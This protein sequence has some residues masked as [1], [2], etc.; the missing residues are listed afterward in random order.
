MRS[1]NQDNVSHLIGL[2]SNIETLNQEYFVELRAAVS[3]ARDS[4]LI[5]EEVVSLPGNIYRTIGEVKLSLL[6]IQK[7][8]GSIPAVKGAATPVKIF[9][10]SIGEFGEE[11]RKIDV[12]LGGGTYVNPV[13]REGLTAKAIG[14]LK[15]SAMGRP[16]ERAALTG[17]GVKDLVIATRVVLDSLEGQMS[18]IA[19]A[20]PTLNNNSTASVIDKISDGIQLRIDAMT[21]A[22]T[23][24][25]L[26][27]SGFEGTTSFL[28]ETVSLTNEAARLENENVQQYLDNLVGIKVALDAVSAIFD[29]KQNV[30]EA[31]SGLVEQLEDIRSSVGSVLEPL[32]F[33][34]E[35]YSVLEPFL[36]LV[37]FLLA[38]FQAAFD[39]ALEASG[40]KGLLDDLTG[41]LLSYLGDFNSIAELDVALNDIFDVLFD[42]LNKIDGPITALTEYL[43]DDLLSSL[44][45]PL[46]GSSDIVSSIKFGTKAAD[47]LTGTNGDDA[48]AGGQDN[49]VLDG[50]GGVDRAIF[51]SN[52]ADYNITK[53][54]DGTTWTVSHVRS[55]TGGQAF[56]GT[57]TLHNIEELIFADSIVDLASI[58]GQFILTNS[59]DSLTVTVA[60]D[61]SQTGIWDPSLNHN[62]LYSTP[63][64][65]YV[66]G[67]V[68]FDRVYGG[69]GDDIIF[70]VENTNLDWFYNAGDY[71]DG[72]AGDDFI[73]VSNRDDFAIGGA[74]NDT[75]SFEG[76]TVG[77]TGVRLGYGINSNFFMPSLPDQM[78]IWE[79]EDLI[80]SKFAD[81]F[82]GDRN[83]A[84]MTGG[85]GN[86][87]IRGLGGNDVLYGNSGD[88]VLIGDRGRD[89]LYGGEGRDL[90]VGGLGN[91]LYHGGLDD[92]ML[93]YSAEVDVRDGSVSLFRDRLDEIEFETTGYIENNLDLPDR[94]VVAPVST[95]NI[96]LQ[97]QVVVK[98]YDENGNLTGQDNLNDI[99]FIHGTSGDDT[100][101]GSDYIAQTMIGG[102]GNDKFFAGKVVSAFGDWGLFGDI[103]YG[104][105]GD[106][107]F[108][109][110]AAR[111][112][113]YAGTGNDTVFISG[114]DHLGGDRYSGKIRDGG[115]NT[116]DLS[117]S[118]YAWRIAFDAATSYMF[119]GGKVNADPSLEDDTRISAET[120][121]S[122]F[123]LL[124]HP[125]QTSSL[126]GGW[127][128]TTSFNVFIGSEF[129]DIIN[130]G[131]HFD[132][133]SRYNY[134]EAFGGAGDDII[135]GAQT[136]GA[137]YGGEG[138]DLLGTYNGYEVV[139]N[140][141][142]KNKKSLFDTDLRTILDGGNGND[143]FIAGDFQETFIGGEGIDS[144]SYHATTDLGRDN[145]LTEVSQEGVVV[146]LIAGTGSSGFAKGDLISGIENVTGSENSDDI[147]GDGNANWLKG[148][149]GDDVIYGASG[150]DVLD[151]DAG[152][153]TLLGGSGNDKLTGGGSTDRLVGGGGDDSL[154]GGTGDD[155]I[156]GGTGKDTLGGGNGVDRLVGG[157]DDDIYILNNAEDVI[158]EEKNGGYDTV[159]VSFDY[160]L[161]KYLETIFLDL[162][163]TANINGIGNGLSNVIVGNAGNNKLLGKGGTDKLQGGAG[164]DTL[165]G[166]ND[167]DTITG[168]DA[169][170]VLKGGKGNDVLK[171][172][173]GNDVLK[174][175]NSKDVLKGGE[176][177]DWLSGGKKSDELGG[178]DGND[179]LTGDGDS[180]KFIFSNGNDKITDFDANDDAETIDLSNAGSIKGFK[181]LKNNH[182]S[183][184]GD[185]VVIVDSRGNELIIQDVRLSDLGKSDFL[186]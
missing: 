86:D 91:D 99:P 121:V 162:D 6:P 104:G 49:D 77:A 171:G 15:D 57:D 94:I 41:T 46:V 48:L 153:D 147:T 148:L 135:F 173:K 158:F 9:R 11:A 37:S 51:T 19:V 122:N 114:S 182:M 139:R 34:A 160:T 32:D 144:L 3:I 128:R 149:A 125:R 132:H 75:V 29:L 184:S 21:S 84:V 2:K 10:E 4:V 55:S 108:V 33:V 56:D 186:F 116:I 35:A 145:Y 61:P 102:D 76:F 85:A 53:E 112:V 118:D 138:D 123:D 177:D 73:T 113:F 105:A 5:L 140:S 23:V 59:G 67:S 68:G 47:T 80:G 16:G 142:F 161:G 62:V 129:D 1:S 164:A 134:I 92:D 7:L 117:D 36:D 52:V 95:E 63:D 89:T 54:A 44:D 103:F 79:F 146:D 165:N 174:G 81:I 185:D 50:L 124:E 69:D 60:V 93:L 18:L 20:N 66:L 143:K 87:S 110:T 27:L 159:M 130:F 178:G 179:T 8:L 183:Q 172:G 58:D 141:S 126:V 166:G 24:A 106:D 96:D 71:V 25:Q 150:D 97:T 181:D 131:G 127:A 31:V 169:Q 30:L 90:F 156:L 154:D 70:T 120:I 72:G 88:D 28:N 82:Y 133:G 38:P 45:Q 100:F 137:I 39:Y 78:E 115:S 22:T 163:G 151:G 12:Q 136:G 98:K 40:L 170:D 43:A 65:D 107:S 152:A 26:N 168:G 176:G 14:L 13:D 83:A 111:E 17:I 167:A 155:T 180:D 175:E 157:K 42:V 101:H 74:G 109:G 119:V 64:R